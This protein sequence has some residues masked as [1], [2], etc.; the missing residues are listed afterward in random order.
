MST[1]FDYV[2]SAYSANVCDYDFPSAW[3]SDFNSADFYD[4]NNMSHPQ[5]SE[6][7]LWEPVPPTEDGDHLVLTTGLINM[8][9]HFRGVANE[10]PH[11]H[12]EK[13]YGICC[14]MK[15]PNVPDDY[16]FLR[17]FPHSL[18]GAAKDWLN[19]LPP[20]LITRWEDLE[21]KFLS[22]F[23][24]VQDGYIN[25]PRWKDPTLGWYS[26]PQHQYQEPPFQNTFMPSPV[27]QEQQ[28]QFH[29]ATAQITPQPSTSKPT[30]K[31]LLEQMTMQNIQFQK[32]NMQ[33][34]Q[35]SMKFQ[36]ET[37]AAIQNL[38]DQ[39]GQ[40]ATQLNQEQSQLSEESTFQTVQIPDDDDSAI[41]IGDEEQ[42][43][44]L[45]TAPPTFP[46]S[47]VPTL[48]PEETDKSFEAQAR[49]SSSYEPGR[50]PSSSHTLAIFKEVEV[51]IPQI[52]YFV[53]CDDDRYADDYIV[54]ESDFNFSSVHDEN[55][56]LLLLFR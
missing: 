33:F 26:A 10:C 38:T 4:E 19:C 28:M 48:A 15:P 29:D 3:Y 20:G 7:S 55:R 21:H 43:Y 5:T 12:L 11:T 1:N 50:P 22:K 42:S 9:P 30:L 54:A 8:L 6:S 2:N 13:F 49:I 45:I 27:Q 44:E 17:A 23:S 36:Q 35:E 56:F 53:D 18:Q 41:D 34:K 47:Y 24:P 25:G 37:Q 16:I 52:D 40:M 51:S 32:G 31:E 14:Y 39:I 46:S